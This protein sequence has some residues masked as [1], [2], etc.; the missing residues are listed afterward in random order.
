[1]S[2]RTALL[3]LTSCVLVAVAGLAWLAP[4]AL[5]GLALSHIEGRPSAPEL[6]QISPENE[7]FLRDH[8]KAQQGFC[9]VPLSPVSYL[10]TLATTGSG[11]S[12]E[13][14]GAYATWIVA[15]DYNS[16]HLDTKKS[17]WWHLSGAALTIWLTRNWT[18]DQILSKA[19]EVTRQRAERANLPRH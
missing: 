5:Y 7:V 12:A 8:L 4:W 11:R 10:S 15:R 13:E 6:R 19:A 2:R 9:I 1:M 3:R 18:P 16:S 14:N 17:L